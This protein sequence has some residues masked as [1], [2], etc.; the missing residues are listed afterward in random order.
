MHDFSFRI[1]RAEGVGARKGWQAQGRDKRAQRLRGL[2]RNWGAG[3]GH[4]CAFAG[5]DGYPDQN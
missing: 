2:K 4:L 1:E 3:R 5:A